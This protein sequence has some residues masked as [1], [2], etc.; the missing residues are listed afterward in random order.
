[1][2]AMERAVKIPKW[3][4][5]ENVAGELGHALQQLFPYK[6]FNSFKNSDCHKFSFFNDGGLKLGHFGILQVIAHNIRKCLGKM[7]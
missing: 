2:P 4:C 3:I 5:M 6:S 7:W 1:M